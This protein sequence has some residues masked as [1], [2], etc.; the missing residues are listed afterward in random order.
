MTLISTQCFLY[1]IP[2]YN[3]NKS[4]LYISS[5]KNLGLYI[6]YSKTHHCML[7]LQLI[8]IINFIPETQV[9]PVLLY[10]TSLAGCA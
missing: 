8:I 1:A 9:K 3:R 6:I 2:R 5:L 10:S 7:S 4:R